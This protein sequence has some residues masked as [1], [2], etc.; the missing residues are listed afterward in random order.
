MMNM[1]KRLKA[2]IFILVVIAF[3]NVTETAYAAN[4]S[5]M[6]GFSARDSGMAGATTA[7]SEDTSC[8][9]KNPAGL[10]RIGNRIDASYENII[11]H[12][13]TMRT[14]GTITTAGLKQK[15]NIN[16]IPGGNAGISYRIPNTDRYPISVGMGM[17]TIGGM[18][19]NYARSR[20][21]TA[22]LAN[23]G[24]YDKMVDMRTMR[25]AP[26][27][28]AAF[29]DR[30]SFGVT[31]NIDIQAL[32]A[33]LAHGATPPFT[34][35]SG[36]GKW[37]I[38]AGAGF[39]LGL[40]Y[41]YNDILS[42]GAAYE[43][44]GWQQ[45]HRKYMD[46]L[47]FIDEPPIMS[48]GISLKPIKNLELTYDTRYINWTDVKLARNSPDSGGFGWRDQWVFAVG[49]E[50]TTFQEKLKLRLGYNYGRSPIQNN[51]MFA[52]ALMPVILEHHFTTGF[53]YFFIKDLSLDFAWEHHFSNAITD[54][55][56]DSGDLI[57]TGTTVT[58]AADI[59]T[60]GLGYKF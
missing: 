9:V 17:F 12:G 43:S 35:T 25:L 34:E 44:H 42:L 48:I 29:N 8:L 13:V 26:G 21:S 28:A 36:G 11:L 33:N 58:A 51:V 53:S 37:D 39:T 38:T 1:V 55:G 19:N 16:Y 14:E 47:P 2:I 27:I 49:S 10:V 41:K 40:L 15:S 60:A 20:I 59:I 30:L 24:N 46:C 7:S 5:R 32:R 54:S 18:A 4:A 45:Y 50:Y 3:F 31:A 56:G 6:L 57:G 22:L 52:N 23:G